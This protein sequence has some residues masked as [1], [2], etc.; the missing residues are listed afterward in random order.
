MAK[1]E[2]LKKHDFGVYAYDTNTMQYMKAKSDTGIYITKV[3][4]KTA[5]E[6][7]GIQE[8]D[9]ILRID[10]QK[11]ERMCEL[12]RYIYT[13]KPKDEVTLKI[14]RNNRKMELK[15]KLEKK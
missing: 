4:E 14:L 5:A 15:V 7:S 11:L 6:K 3:I 2:S 9:I 12:R 8:E 1:Q 10:D 13:K